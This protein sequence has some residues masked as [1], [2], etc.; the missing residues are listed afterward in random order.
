MLRCV[1][2]LQVALH[3][4]T[5]NPRD[6]HVQQLLVQTSQ[7]L[8]GMNQI[9]SE[10]CSAAAAIDSSAGGTQ[11]SNGTTAADTA[12]EAAEA[13]AG[14]NAVQQSTLILSSSTAA[15]WE[16]NSTAAAPS[17]VSSDSTAATAAANAGKISS[18]SSSAAAAAAAAAALS[19]VADILKKHGA[20]QQALQL[21]YK[22]VALQ[23]G[24]ASYALALAQT[25]ELDY[26]YWKMLKVVLEYC[27]INGATRVG[28]LQLQVRKRL[29]SYTPGQ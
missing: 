21:Y 15:T 6:K 20:I 9:L 11:S 3:L 22:A 24:C 26:N 2:M 19:L 5:H 12:A 10:L 18:T 23:P 28:P 25:L 7:Q 29:R 27:C 17:P 4:L 16:M 1:H 8:A 13:E 14:C